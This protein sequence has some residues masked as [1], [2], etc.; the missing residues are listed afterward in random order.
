MRKFLGKLAFLFAL[1]AASGAVIMAVNIPVT[2]SQ[3]ENDYAACVADK[4]HRLKSIHVP[5]IILVGNS[6]LAFGIDSHMIQ[7]EFGMPVVNLGYHGGMGNAFHENMARPNITSGDLVI[8]CHSNYSDD[9]RVPDPALAWH[10]LAY[11]PDLWELLSWEDL[12]PA[13]LAGPSCVLRSTYH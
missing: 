8:V 4:V 13:L 7:D 5:K 2:R 1:F 12:L 6:N 10:T 11:H 9:S 3:R